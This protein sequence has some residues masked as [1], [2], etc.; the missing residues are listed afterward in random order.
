MSAALR[1]ALQVLPGGA[2]Q[3]EAVPVGMEVAQQQNAARLALVYDAGADWD[4]DAEL[5]LYRGV[6]LKLLRRY[7]RMAMS[8]GRLPSLLGGEAPMAFRSKYRSPYAGGFENAVIFVHDME[9]MLGRLE[10]GQQRII[11]HVV[12]EE[13]TQDEAARLLGK[14]RRRVQLQY[15]DAM[16]RLT[17]M[18]LAGGMIRAL[19][20]A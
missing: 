9:K 4:G 3:G 13:Y 20:Q 19:P 1:L 8:V 18:L 14:S 2:N 6:T 5:V 11:A 15:V 12:L 10:E 17:A 7:Q 16:D